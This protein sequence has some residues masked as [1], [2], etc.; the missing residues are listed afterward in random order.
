MFLLVSASVPAQTDRFQCAPLVPSK[1]RQPAYGA[2][3][4]QPR[5]EGFYEKNVSQP[6][7]ELVSLTRSAPG[8]LTVDAEGR[9]S[10]RGSLKLDTRLVI[11]P[12]RSN[13]L[14]RVDAGLS[15]GASVGWSSR[16][17][18]QATG[19]QLRDLGFL[20]LVG[21][22]PMVLAPVSTQVGD[23]GH[24]AY[25]VLRPSVAVSSLSWRAYRLGSP[26]VLPGDWQALANKPLFAWERIALAI[27]LPT[28][29]LS[30]RIDVAGLDS[31]GQ[32]LPLLQFVVLGAND[33]NP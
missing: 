15:R 9:L 31:Q 19:L 7:L 32:A 20:A 2:A 30:L 24:T 12:M 1:A 21:A 29:G 22:E 16:T 26:A 10:L 27:P 28:D 13:P 33:D 8:S 17:M 3:P 5:C 11:Q 14:Y 23:E 18:L 25:A 4:G 6:F